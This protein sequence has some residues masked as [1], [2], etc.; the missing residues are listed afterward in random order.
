MS[1]PA[2]PTIQRTLLTDRLRLVLEAPH[3]AASWHWLYKAAA[4][5]PEADRAWLRENVRKRRPARG[6]GAILAASF[7]DA[8]GGEEFELRAALD[9]CL[10]GEVPIDAALAVL[11]V[12][13]SRGMRRGRG[14]GMVRVLRG[15]GFI[16]LS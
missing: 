11:N 1:P 13:Y 16:E 15:C 8:L 10:R 4:A 7:L 3:R 14:K 2:A 6:T 9:T 12:M 5:C